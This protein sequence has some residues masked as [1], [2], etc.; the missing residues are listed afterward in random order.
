MGIAGTTGKELHPWRRY[1]SEEKFGGSTTASAGSCP[2]IAGHHQR[3]GRTPE[4]KQVEGL[5]A[6]GQLDPPTRIAIATFLET[7][8]GYLKERHTER[9]Y[10]ADI[11]YLRSFFG[12][13]CASLKPGPRKK[14]MRRRRPKRMRLRE[15]RKRRKRRRR[16]R[17]S[18]R[19]K[20]REG[21]KE[22]PPRMKHHRYTAVT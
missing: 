2:E 3:A 14:K 5:E 22:V 7:F 21:P 16:Q 9:G 8:C 11:S 19:L 10:K 1:S 4:K 12:P 20:K 13:I 6:T 15:R 17:R 18:R